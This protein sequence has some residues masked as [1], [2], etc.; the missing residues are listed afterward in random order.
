M[1]IIGHPAS[2]HMATNG[3]RP[4]A[5]GFVNNGPLAVP[6]TRPR[7]SQLQPSTPRPLSISTAPSLRAPALSVQR[8]PDVP[9]LLVEP[10]R[11]R[12]TDA[13]GHVWVTEHPD[14]QEDETPLSQ[15]PVLVHAGGTLEQPKNVHAHLWPQLSAVGE[16]DLAIVDFGR[17]GFL[18]SNEFQAQRVMDAVDY[19]VEQGYSP[20]MMALSGGSKGAYAS[21]SA[22]A[23]L[24]EKGQ[25]LA[26]L[27]LVS[28]VLSAYTA[29]SV[30][31]DKV[32]SRDGSKP[33]RVLLE[34]L[35]RH[36]EREF[37]DMTQVPL[38]GK[39]QTFVV[40]GGQDW[41]N[42]DSTNARLREHF[43]KRFPGRQRKNLQ[44]IKYEDA[45]HRLEVE[46][47]HVR[48]MLAFLYDSPLALVA[49]AL[50]SARFRLQ[51][52]KIDA[53]P[54]RLSNQGPPDD[55]EKKEKAGA[56][57][58]AEK[59][60]TGSIEKSKPIARR[61]GGIAGWVNH[62]K[63]VSDAIKAISRPPFLTKPSLDC[64]PD[65]ER[66]DDKKK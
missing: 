56:D 14:H 33:L 63:A 11:T 21:A 27:I 13:P 16:L 32:I 15:R 65:S 28:P 19:L 40:Q 36:V 62:R 61:L 58:N 34:F 24:R 55:K 10:Q 44:F 64:R 47:H 9:S 37:L 50:A 7:V 2:S 20:R 25:H 48:W 39:V 35:C 1:T 59:S 49:G 23:Q 53:L 5:L 12:L 6:L 38:N 52:L 54:G 30:L 66:K 57:T 4:Q 60:K 18:K 46:K 42:N 51:N 29:L 3:L 43:E 45:G 26:A 31:R 22:A 41:A 8:I 17:F